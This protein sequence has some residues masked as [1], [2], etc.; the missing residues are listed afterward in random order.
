MPTYKPA[1]TV[2]ENRTAG[3]IDD[4]AARQFENVK[5]TTGAFGDKLVDYADV[6]SQNMGYNIFGFRA[7]N[8]LQGAGEGLD[9]YE[10]LRN[11]G[12][13]KEEALAK[14]FGTTGYAIASAKI[15]DYVGKNNIV[16]ERLFG[17]NGIVDKVD[18]YGYNNS[19]NN[20]VEE[21]FLQNKLN[22][23]T[24]GERM[25][26]PENAKFESVKTI[27]GS[28]GE[29]PIGDIKRLIDTYGG[30]ENDWKKQAGKINSDKYVFDVHWYELNSVQYEA[31]LKNRSTR[32]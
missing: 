15:D 26:I 3:K 5:K 8:Y 21:V 20:I 23:E 7:G 29:K 16:D 4:K 2:L 6:F 22:Y 25:F 9:E 27:A 17:K 10:R 12:Y 19:K 11:L 14:A 24:N 18:D 32:R 31:K 30:N 13:S 1:Q 28:G